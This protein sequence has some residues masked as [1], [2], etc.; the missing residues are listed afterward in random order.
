METFL[1]PFQ[2]FVLL[3]AL[4]ILSASAHPKVIKGTVYRNGKPASGIHVTVDKSTDSYFTSFD[5]KYELKAKLESK[6]IKFTFPD[7]EEKLGVDLNRSD[8][9][10]FGAPVK[11]AESGRTDQGKT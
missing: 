6:W 1:R 4:G 9:I 8:I 5:G 3:F 7:K 2:L 10:D 11:G